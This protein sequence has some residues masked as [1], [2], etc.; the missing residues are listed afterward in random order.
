MDY[1]SIDE[2]DVEKLRLA[3]LM[4]FKKKSNLPINAISSTSGE[5]NKFSNGNSYNNPARNNNRGHFPA[6]NRLYNKRTY[7]NVGFRRPTH[8]NNNLIAIIPMDSEGDSIN[9]S[10]SKNLPKNINSKDTTTSDTTKLTN[11]QNLNNE[12]STKFSRLNNESGSEE[13]DDSEAEE[14]GK[15]DSDDGDVLLLGEEDED[16]DD[17]D[18][19]M[20]IMEAEIA[21]GDV[22]SNK[23]EKKSVKH[24]NKKDKGTAKNKL[25]SKTKIDEPPI[26]INQ[27]KIIEDSIP[28]L[29][30]PEEELESI[31][32]LE[33]IR[34][35]SSQ[36]SLLKSRIPL[37]SPSPPIRKR[38]ISPY[39]KLQKRSPLSRSPRRRSPS[40]DR[41]RYSPLRSRLYRRSL[42]PRRSPRRMSPLRE[43]NLSPRRYSPLKSRYPYR[44]PSPRRRRRSLSRDISPIRR[45]LSPL[46]RRS[47]SPPKIKSKSRSPKIRP[48]VRRRSPSP[49]KKVMRSRP[50]SPVNIRRKD[51]KNIDDDHL[52]K[53]E[54]VKTVDNQVESRLIDPVLEARKRKFE[55]NKPIEP[56]SKKII[57]KKTNSVQVAIQ[58][59]SKETQ[60]EKKELEIKPKTSH[61][62]KKVKKVTHSFQVPKNISI[63]MNNDLE[64]VHLRRVIKINT[65]SDKIC[66]K[67]R[68]RIVFGHEERNETLVEEADKFDQHAENIPKSN[69]TVTKVLHSEAVE[70][71]SASEEELSEEEISEEEVSEENVDEESEKE[72]GQ[73]SSDSCGEYIEEEEEEEKE[74]EEEE[75]E[76]LS[77]GVNDKEESLQHNDT[78]D[79]R[80]EL[81]RRRALRLN[82]IQVEVKKKPESFYPAR[83]LQSAIRGVVGSSS[84]N[85]VK[86]KKHSKIP[87]MS[88]KTESNSDGRRVIV[89]NRDN[90]RIDNVHEDYN[91]AV[92]SYASVK[93]LKGKLKKVSVRLRTTGVNNDNT[94]Q[95]GLRKI[96]KRNINVTD[97]D[98]M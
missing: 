70:V 44:S 93:R 92:E 64:N 79:L 98:Q 78:V 71:S 89:M 3:A 56:S 11:F 8:A 33:E 16:L 81:K 77:Q 91:D 5:F 60:N 59:E 80:T 95:K 40:L 34:N 53:R 73:D 61:L 10:A 9:D 46:R 7:T 31:K 69:T 12:V 32:T 96:I 86:R 62:A 4:T 54:K 66:N 36:S 30:P 39:S 75:I 25:N 27:P 90:T 87:E 48:A 68:P 49:L 22:K 14:D 15:E 19:L 20:D 2:D 67:K 21:G 45:R 74:E 23:K 26:L 83:L 84:T 63:K 57:L 24:K 43:K 88:I 17:L 47:R 18:K 94:N 52:K 82:M 58:T 37:R 51:S 13:S 50:I 65:P 55:S 35:A 28:Q 85:E 41:Y 97:F 38:S 29:N 72:D 1:N 6:P 76:E 42:S